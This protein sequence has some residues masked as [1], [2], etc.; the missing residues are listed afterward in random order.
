MYRSKKGKRAGRKITARAIT[1]ATQNWKN[2]TFTYGQ[3]HTSIGAA[4]PG[5]GCKWF[6]TELYNGTVEDRSKRVTRVLG[7]MEH[8]LQIADLVWPQTPKVAAT[9]DP[10]FITDYMSR[11]LLKG[12]VMYTLRNQANETEH[13]EM[14]TCVVR[15]DFNFDRVRTGDLN[16]VKNNIYDIFGLGLGIRG[17]NPL[18]PNADNP[19]LQ[20]ASTDIWMSPMFC[21]WFKVVKRKRF[22]IKPGEE[23]RCSLALR[24]RTI[25]PGDLTSLLYEETPTLWINKTR[26]FNYVK[27]TRFNIFK[28]KARIAGF[29]GQTAS[30]DPEGITYTTPTIIMESQYKYKAKFAYQQANT[31]YITQAFG[32]FSSTAN[33]MTDSDF[34]AGNE[35]SAAG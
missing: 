29:T 10:V 11:Y 30:L 26:Q 19:S 4:A 14:Y 25:C 15:K 13:L 23:K 20:Y 24:T 17:Q 28:L 9:S 21:H 34:V 32:T 2:V 31:D 33:V 27:G 7:D 6:T 8:I 5:G 35:T 16:N 1:E 3:G 12:K 18:A 22:S